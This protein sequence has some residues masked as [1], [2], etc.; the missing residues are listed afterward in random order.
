MM[1]DECRTGDE[2][3]VL[4]SAFCVPIS[5][6]VPASNAAETLSR[7]LAALASQTYPT[8]AYEVIVVDDG[9]TDDTAGI[10]RAAG[11][12]VITQP[13]AGP[14]AA[15]NRGAAAARGE[16]LLFTDSD[17]APAP[18][19][20][21]A[22]VVPFADARVAGAKGAYLTRQRDIV[23]RFT[24]LEYQERYDRMA[25]AE[26]ID[27]I[28]TYSAAYRRDVFLANRGFDTIFPTAS[29]EDQELS[30]RLAEKGYRLAFAAEAQ[31][32]HRHNPTL[33]AYV[34]RKFFI[35]YWKALLARWHPGR[36]VKDSH[37]PQTLKL[38]MGLAAAMLA[39]LL[40]GSLVSLSMGHL[41]SLGFVVAAI[42]A[43]AF[44][45]SA[46]PF[47]VKAGRRDRGVLLPAVGLLWVRALALG[48]GFALGLVRF[49]GQVGARRPALS[50]W[51][52]VLKRLID[53]TVALGGLILSALPMA[54][55]ALA[56]RLNSSG[57]AIFVQTRV[58]Q[59]GQP[60][61]IFKF[62]TMV[63]RAEAQLP[64]LVNLDALSQPA[65]KLRD[66]PR[67]T[68][69]GRFL[70]RFS[71]DELPQLVNVL[72]GEMSMVGPRPEEDALVTRYTDDQ[73][74]R[75]AVKP[76]MTGPMQVNGRG[77]LPFEQRLA[78]ELDYIEHYSLRRDL[79]I[80][81]RTL[82]AVLRGE[83]AY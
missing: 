27:F 11:V 13:N 20:I 44:L 7:C 70:R 71:L 28:D 69:V 77:D 80:L 37:T 24:Q 60:F 75:L 36:M 32:Y 40:V 41:W 12:R 18:G 51:Q 82:P 29:V 16:L 45:A 79:A 35:G 17:C 2:S 62:R 49:R 73:R 54:I 67:V 72:A 53:L 22:L 4:H 52:R 26:T 48:S 23:P 42:S 25:G 31:V 9:S 64:Q 47:L 55:I 21:A 74:R 56:V 81:L 50:G 65:F 10:A 8:S 38:Q 57:P 6:I 39:G 5:V 15:R 1:N 76:G 63:D 14:A 19:W 46:G 43:L 33:A 61:R 3:A 59:N 68:R 58:G 34:R 66:D 30:F 78:L 83:G